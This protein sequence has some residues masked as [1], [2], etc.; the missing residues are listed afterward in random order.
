LTISN[1][2][3]GIWVALEW[4]GVPGFLPPTLKRFETARTSEG[5]INIPM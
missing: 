2:P 1:I 5:T 4:S 3:N